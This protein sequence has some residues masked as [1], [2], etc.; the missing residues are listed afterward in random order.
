MFY[1]YSPAH[2]KALDLIFTKGF[3]DSIQEAEAKTP[4]V[5]VTS[6]VYNPG[7]LFS[8]PQAKGFENVAQ[9]IMLIRFNQER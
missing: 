1:C 6:A 2:D 9:K 4:D 3:R 7:Q 8:R 5:G